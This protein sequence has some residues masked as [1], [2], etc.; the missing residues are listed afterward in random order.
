MAE[1]ILQAWILRKQTRTIAFCSTVRQA[2][3][4][5]HY[6][7]QSGYRSIALSGTT[8]RNERMNARKQL[9]SGKIDI[10]FTVDLFNE[11]VDIPTVDTLLFVRPT[12]S[13]AVFT[14]QIGRG[15]RLAEGKSHCVII[16]LIGNYRNADTK[17]SVF[18]PEPTDKFELKTVQTSLPELCSVNLETEIIDLV[19]EMAR[20]AA[21]HKQRLIYEYF[22]LKEEMGS[23]PTYLDYHLKSGIIATNVKKEFGSYVGMLKEAGEL[24]EQELEAFELY[25]DWIEVAESTRMNESYKMV[26]LSYMLSRGID[27]W[28]LPVIAED[29]ALFL[30]YLTSKGYTNKELKDTNIN[31]LKQQIE[32]MPMTYFRGKTEGIVKF[33]NKV[34]SLSFDIIEAANPI[35]YEWTKQV[36]EYRLH[37]HFE[38][39]IQK[40]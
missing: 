4:L 11:G 36:C 6:F 14:Q 15:L 40:Q 35:I 34:F 30:K 21:S 22:R 13:I 1:K 5:S 33:E 37:E 32:K 25:K 17:L 7:A 24:N 38:R 8:P 18:T 26:L 20:K 9:E 28:Y 2:N 39:K 16:D 23:R 29:A 3:F 31:K 10:I 27:N 19:K 12:E